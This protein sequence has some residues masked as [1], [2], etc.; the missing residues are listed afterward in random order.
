MDEEFRFTRFEG[1]LPGVADSVFADSVG[2]RPWEIERQEIEGGWEAYRAQLTAH[3]PFSE[4]NFHRTLSDATRLYLTISGEPVFDA[5]GAFKGYRGVGKDITARKRAEQLQA[6]EHVVNRSLADT[7][8]VTAAIHA[9]VRAICETEDWEC[10]RYFRWD[11][12]GGVLRFGDGWGVPEAAVEQFIEKS[13]DLSYAPGAGLAGRVW[14]TGRPLWVPDVTQDSRVATAGLFRDTGMRG[15]FVFP[16]MSEAEGKPIGVL[17]FN[18]RKVREPDERLLQAVQVIGSQIGQFLQRKHAEEVVRKSEERFRSLTS[19]SSDMYWEQDEHYRFTSSSGSGPDWIIKGR[20]DAV[21]KTRWDFNYINMTEKDWAAHIALLDARQPFRDFELC[22]FD[23]SGRKVWVSVSGEPVFDASGVFTGYR[24]VGKDITERKRAEQMQALEHKINRC[25]AEADSASVALKAAMRAVCE[26]EGWGCGRY[27]R[28]DEQAALLRFYEFWSVSGPEIER[29][30]DDSRRT[31]YGRGV[32]L[33]GQVWQSGAPLWVADITQDARVA[34]KALAHE[35]GMRGA[36]VVPVTAEGKT[37]GVLIFQSREIRE[38]DERLL[39]AMYVIG[40]QIGQFM[41]RKQWEEELRRFRAGM[42]VSEDMIWL[43]DP[44]R[45]GI[46]DVNDAVCRKLGYRREELLCM[47]PEDIICLSREELSAIYSR[48]IAGGEGDTAEGWY[49]RKDGSRFPVEAFRRAVKSEG[50]HVIVAV[51][52]D[53]T[54][55]RAAEEE[56]RRFKLA[57]DNSADMIVLIDRATMRFV[58]V[59]ATACSLLGYSREELLKKG[60]QDL[61]PVSREELEKSYDELIANP[62]LSSGMYTYYR[63]KDG[64]TLPFESTRRVLHSGDTYIIAAISRDIRERIAAETALKQSNERFNAA[65]RATN[66]VIWDWNLVTDE[67]WWNENF[68]KVF[69][70]PR[71]GV[72]PTIKSWHDGIHP[73]DRDRIVNGVR[74]LLDRDQENWSDE[75]RFRRHDG[76][77]AHV[78]DRGHV[79]RDDKGKAVRMIGAMADI[80]ERKNAEERLNYLAQFDALT[81]LPNRHL[82]Q[83]R[84]VQTMAQAKR[85]SR[86]MAVLFIDLDRF[87]LVNDTQGHGAGDKLL[88][89]AAARLSQCIRSGDT[90]GRLSGDE[91]AAILSNL[92]KPGDASLVAQ[93]IVD[94]L[95]R[96]FDLDGHR[97]FVTGSVG[98]TLF[99]GDGEEPGALIMNADAAMYRAKEQ[100][101]NNYQYF[102]REMNERALARVQMEASMRRALERSEFVLHYQPKLDLAN[103]AIC[104]IEALLRWAHPEKGLISPAEFIPVL[105]ETGLIVP[106]GEWVTREAC[107]Q[108][109]AWQQ[110][111][112]KVPPVAVNLSAR[113]FQQKNLEAGLRQ[114]LA[115]TGVDPALLQFEI[116]E[117]LL[118]KDPEEAARTLRGLKAA[119]VKLSVDDFGTGYSSLAYLKRFPLDELKV[120]RAFINDIVT[121]PDDAAIT[122]AIISLAHSLKLRVVAEGVETEAQLNLL[123]LHSCDEMQGYYF[124]R[125]VAAAE[126]EAM[127]R[128]GRRLTRTHIGA[129]TAPAVLLLDDNEQDLALLER[130]LRSEE[131]KVLTATSI[132]G[133]FTLLASHPVGVV[134]SDQGMPGMSGAEFLGKLRK[135]YP[136]AIRVAI[137]G[138]HDPEAI[139]DAVDKAGVHKFLSK[140][141]DSERLR[142]EVRE[143]YQHYRAAAQS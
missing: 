140:E 7:D 130:A 138:T 98:I 93:K 83:D 60:P 79:I 52:R 132:E 70:H 84:L 27:L 3:Q 104:G 126:L 123:A 78:F 32:G 135:L 8:S 53:V 38:P 6:L 101:R 142:S 50:S 2:K 124:S 86:P 109:R 37:I 108:I 42:D 113:Q 54:E 125:P 76:G 73:E 51:V 117:S 59:N 120:D 41:Q 15:A 131:F 102:T 47:A 74:Q 119:G 13:R 122:L 129:G 100:G 34:R 12:R 90:V 5:S 72:K 94:I 14:Q 118:M 45:M 71:E 88:K 57:M 64:S 69:G 139:A 56:L 58:D 25:L 19:L 134:V 9:S 26:T 1:H 29:Y 97:T 35:A 136:N 82:F 103:G 44:V 89:E 87:K 23:E 20:R 49:R 4:V 62:S 133:A 18:S 36:F 141:W 11:E 28:V 85:S 107:R 66:D 43:L 128:D 114:V 75:Y 81:G 115:E 121:E 17:A 99:P 137:T 10:G 40:S 61:L 92:A 95:A 143:A 48:L 33:V 22:R 16:V 106:V 30:I 55:R 91:F 112:V 31:V 110:A 46:I 105:E 65:A 116:T 67:I 24:G 63:C 127:L 80:S 111:G 77:Y 21:G 39:K 96:P 68:N